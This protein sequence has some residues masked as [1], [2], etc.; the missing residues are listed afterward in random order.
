MSRNTILRGKR[1]L[2]GQIGALFPMPM[3]NRKAK[4]KKEI[5]KGPLGDDVKLSGV[6]SP[7]S[8]SYSSSPE[9]R[10]SLMMEASHGYPSPPLLWI[11]KT[12]D[13]LTEMLREEKHRANAP[14][15]SIWLKELG[16]HVG[17]KRMYRQENEEGRETKRGQKRREKRLLDPIFDEIHKMAVQYLTY[18]LPVVSLSIRVF[19]PD[20]E[21]RR[22]R[23]SGVPQTSVSDCEAIGLPTI[24]SHEM[25][26]RLQRPMEAKSKPARP[27]DM[28][29]GIFT[30][31]K[32]RRLRRGG[33]PK[34]SAADFDPTGLTPVNSYMK[35]SHPQSSTKAKRKVVQ[36]KA[37]LDK[38]TVAFL[39]EGLN[40][41]WGNIGRCGGFEDQQPEMMLFVE[42]DAGPREQRWEWRHIFEHLANAWHMPIRVCH[43]PPAKTRWHRLV[44]PA[45]FVLTAQEDRQEKRIEIKIGIVENT[46]PVNQ[47]QERLPEGR[48][49]RTIP[50]TRWGTLG[51]SRSYYIEPEDWVRPPLSRKYNPKLD[52]DRT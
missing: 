1:E 50:S 46:I 36:P 19:H 11:T 32:S 29:H 15:V 21:P 35:Y 17:G 52:D 24:D 5:K 28:L 34:P 9:I 22:S 27:Q 33:A 37:M 51:S 3:R 44:R 43:L 8:A 26:S 16:F 25:Y 42:S 14:Q 31:Q 30:N 41:W 40:A 49:L 13:E 12:L 6:Q 38:K 23:Q 48:T 47:R 4:E 20:H 2:R 39:A 18:D 7:F 45:Q 10:E